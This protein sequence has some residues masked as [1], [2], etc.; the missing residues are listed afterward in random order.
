MNFLVNPFLKRITAF[1]FEQVLRP[2]HLPHPTGNN[3]VKCAVK[4]ILS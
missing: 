2:H 4:E 3:N 1:H